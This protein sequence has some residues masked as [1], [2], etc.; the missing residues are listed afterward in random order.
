MCSSDL[1][2]RALIRRILQRGMERGEFRQMDLEYGTYIVL[3]PMMFLM[4][5]N[6]SMGPCS[7]PDEVFTPEQY[8]RT[9]IDNILHGLCVRP[10]ASA[11]TSA[12]HDPSAG[13]QP[14]PSSLTPS[15]K[16]SRTS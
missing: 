9:Q 5:W 2:G 11:G 14:F 8:I 3:A 12:N 4:L 6:N 16:R 10:E 1:P 7:L 13:A 15:S